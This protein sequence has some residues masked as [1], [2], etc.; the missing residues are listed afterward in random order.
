MKVTIVPILIGALGTVTKGLLKGLED[1]EVGG[2]VEIIQMT[3]LLR[4]ARILRRVQETWGDLLSLNVKNSRGVNNNTQK[5][6]KSRLCGKRNKPV[7][8]MISEYSTPLK[9]LNQYKSKH[10]WLGMVIHWKLCKRL[11]FDH[12]DKWYKHKKMWCIEFS[13]TLRYEKITQSRTEDHLSHL[14]SNTLVLLFGQFV[15]YYYHYYY[16]KS[17]KTAVSKLNILLFFIKK[18][19]FALTLICRIFLS[20]SEEMKIFFFFHIFRS[21]KHFYLNHLN[22]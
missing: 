14:V 22:P 7:N 11:K 5:N 15:I 17:V 19:I 21:G 9:K 8:P 13:W 10:E 12:A 6:C 4:T 3:A 16:F 20:R 18:I 2:R 1:L